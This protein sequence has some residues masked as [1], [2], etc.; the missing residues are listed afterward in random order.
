MIET[1]RTLFT[2]AF[3]SAAGNDFL[4]A[5]LLLGLLTSILLGL[6]SWGL[7]VLGRIRRAFTYSLYID[8]T[9]SMYAAIS[10]WYYHKYPHKFKNVE[11]STEYREED[12]E[13]SVH[14]KV[15]QFNDFNTLWYNRRLLFIYKT[16]KVL[17]SAMN[18]EVR[19]QDIY[20]I[21][22]LFAKKAI[23]KLMTEAYEFYKEQEVLVH[24][25][26]VY[27]HGEYGGELYRQLLTDYKTLDKVFLK[28][29][30]DIMSDIHEFLDN[31]DHYRK[32]GIK[33]KRN[34][35]FGGPPGTGKTSLVL[36]IA[37]ELNMRV[38][39][40][41]PS[42]F[43]GD[44]VFERMIYS[45]EPNSIILF[46]DVDIFFTHRDQKPAEKT[47]KVSFQAFLNVLDGA[48][49]P[50]DVLIF[51]TTNHSEKL[52]SA[53]MRNG[54]V[55]RNEFIG[56]PEKEQAEMFMSDFYEE[57]IELN[58]F[59]GGIPMSEIQDACLRNKSWEMAAE[60]LKIQNGIKA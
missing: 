32:K 54:R 2:D 29:K 49:S 48:T 39:Y 4:N 19:N 45:V 24:G 41:N 58:S 26:K 59:K 34:Y 17:E 1:I 50:S 6:K 9:S 38:Y 12:G 8:N 47:T 28:Q 20:E 21:Y 11:A 60:E 5:G 33:C 25:L 30:D 16:K 40:I 10:D 46:E 22:G 27:H 31:R 53:L 56:F 15:R 51:M 36:A 55:D 3:A 52:D 14:I 43:S 23:N 37:G 44:S 7:W 35:L 57:P 42:K 18:L 13:R